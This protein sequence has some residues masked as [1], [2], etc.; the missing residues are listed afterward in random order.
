M[1]NFIYDTEKEESCVTG[2]EGYDEFISSELTEDTIQ[3]P[4]KGLDR[5]LFGIN[6]CK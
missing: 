4:V 3:S 2:K 5:G 1:T 6:D